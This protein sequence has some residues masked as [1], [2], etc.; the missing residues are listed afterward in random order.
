MENRLRRAESNLTAD[1]LF[2]VRHGETLANER[3]IEAGSLDYPLTKKGVKEASFIAQA[4]SKVKINAVYS[5]PVFRAVETA[6]IL[7]R[8]HKLKVKPLEELTEAKLKPKFVGKKGRHHILTTPSA[9]SETNNE[10]LERT[11]KAI[12]IIKKEAEGNV[13]VVSH[14]DVITAMLEGVV[15]RRVSTE[16]YY[17]LHPDPAALSIVEIKNRPFL[18]LY[19]YHRKMF[20]D[21]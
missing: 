20:A 5:S 1:Y 8:P 18:V 12:K 14:G 11:S 3:G 9:Y 16:K 4:L 7:A 10:L 15:E 2:I 6:K 19:N 13:I 21:F 17:A